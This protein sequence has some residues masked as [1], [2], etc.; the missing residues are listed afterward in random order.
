[1]SFLSP[2]FRLYALLSECEP[3]NPAVLHRLTVLDIL[4]DE[5]YGQLCQMAQF[6]GIYEGWF[7][8]K[9]LFELPESKLHDVKEAL[10]MLI[11]VCEELLVSVHH[12]NA[13]MLVPQDRPDFYSV[14]SM[15]LFLSKLRCIDLYYNKTNLEDDEIFDIFKDSTVKGK[16]TGEIPTGVKYCLKCGAV[17]AE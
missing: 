8:P 6:R 17:E 16:F 9:K 12:G 2:A 1:M 7:S 3:S 14:P 4:N 15:K 10:P 5:Q 13:W 11:T